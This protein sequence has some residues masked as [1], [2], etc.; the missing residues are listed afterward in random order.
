LFGHR[1]AVQ[2]LR[3]ELL[4]IGA[5]IIQAL[6]VEPVE[7]EAQAQD[8][9]EFT[10]AEEATPTEEEADKQDKAEQVLMLVAVPI[11]GVKQQIIT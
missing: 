6:T 4:T 7:P 8:Y 10:Q 9:K 2:E 5:N 3:Q 11:P 1:E